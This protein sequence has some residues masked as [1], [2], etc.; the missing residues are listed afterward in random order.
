MH[1]MLR[2]GMCVSGDPCDPTVLLAPPTMCEWRVWHAIWAVVAGNHNS[3]DQSYHQWRG[4][5]LPVVSAATRNSR[6][7]VRVRLHSAGPTLRVAH[8]R[9]AGRTTGSGNGGGPQRPPM[10]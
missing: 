2:R 6:V 10:Q 7:C 9:H 8:Q 1:R 5:Q 3:I 4:Q